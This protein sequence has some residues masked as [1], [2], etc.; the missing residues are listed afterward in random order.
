MKRSKKKYESSKLLEPSNHV[1]NANEFQH[2]AAVHYMD[3]AQINWA[4]G[5]RTYEETKSKKSFSQAPSVYYKSTESSK[6]NLFLRKI[7]HENA[8]IPSHL[9]FNS[10]KHL[11]G[12]GQNPSMGLLKF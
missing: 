12:K 9:N 7:H 1:T 8:E 10:F 3:P 11:T 4:F 6:V 5:L 2:L